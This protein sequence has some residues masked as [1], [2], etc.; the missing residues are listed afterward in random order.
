MKEAITSLRIYPLHSRWHVVVK[1]LPITT[2]LG[3]VKCPP[4]TTEFF[5]VQRLIGKQIKRYVYITFVKSAETT[6][7]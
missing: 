1:C 4:I 6:L 5:C 7:P 3:V 2:E